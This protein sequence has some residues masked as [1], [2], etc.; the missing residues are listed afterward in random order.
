MALES[1]PSPGSASTE[2]VVYP[3]S[4][5][6]GESGLQAFVIAMLLDLL[7]DYVSRLERPVFVSTNQFFYYKKGD[8]R[9]A[10]APD[11][12]TIDDISLHLNQVRC[13][14]TWEPDVRPPTLA[15]EIVADDD[16]KDY[17]DTMVERYQQLGVR[18][19]VRYDPTHR[20]RRKRE[21]LT[22]FVRADDG[23][24]VRRPVFG[25]RVQLVS[26]DLWLVP[27]ANDALRLGVGP[28]GASLWPTTS[29]RAAAEAARA[30]AEAERAKAEA[31]L[32]RAER[33]RAQAESERAQ[34]EA[35][36]A[37]AEAARATAAESEL[38]RLRA[39]LAALKGK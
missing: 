27:H 29:E 31:E 9:A 20:G 33:E 30:D 7:R 19:L 36:R 6:M 26:Y 8:P 32:A 23:Q 13:W 17:A 34:A 1:T 22:H 12:Y 14:K 18:E 5:F 11:V 38:A 25:D 16:R 2:R 24:L 35:A 21:L 15:L 39:E 10:V 28:Q 4:D 3:V 37:D